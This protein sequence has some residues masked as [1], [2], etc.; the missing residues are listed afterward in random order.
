MPPANGP[1]QND[2]IFVPL[3]VH[4]MGW[5]AAPIGGSRSLL[6]PRRATVLAEPQ[7]RASLAVGDAQAGSRSYLA[8]PAM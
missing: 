2:L 1:D 4:G 6:G 7:V 5:A 3:P 8:A